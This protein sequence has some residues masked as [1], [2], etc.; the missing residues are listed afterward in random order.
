M[1]VNH[2]TNVGLGAV[3]ETIQ[4]GHNLFGEGK[5]SNAGVAD[6]VLKVGDI[7]SKK[8]NGEL[9]I[10]DAAKKDVEGIIVGFNIEARTV[11]VSGSAEIQYVKGG[12]IDANVVKFASGVTFDTIVELQT[13]S[14]TTW[15]KSI[16][17]LT[18]EIGCEV[19]FGKTYQ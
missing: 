15:K 1:G 11:P 13:N 17:Q 10:F 5:I 16:L 8:A 3:K 4:I 7:L 12:L 14:E 2:I 6:V 9:V 18:E 19:H